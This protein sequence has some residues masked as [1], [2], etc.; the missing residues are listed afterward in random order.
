MKYYAFDGD[1][2]EFA[3]A[4]T[5]EEALSF[6]DDMLQEY[7]DNCDPEWPT[8]VTTVY[9]LK[10]DRDP[11]SDAEFEGCTPVY[12][13]AECNRVELDPEDAEACGCE[14]SCDYRMEI[15]L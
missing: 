5:V 7:R 6:A 8:G 14:Y 1:N 9:V 12:R 10:G 15:I 2:Y 3:E 4:E 13:S 11:D